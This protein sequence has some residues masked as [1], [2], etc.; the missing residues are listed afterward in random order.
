MLKKLPSLERLRALREVARTGG[1]SA[2]ADALAITQ[3]A[4]SN[5]IRL[6]EEQLGVTLLERVGRRV[7]LTHQGEILVGAA[8]RAFKELEVA[9][10]EISRMQAEIMGVLVV[11][12]GPTVTRHLL[13]PVMAD[14][15]TRHPGIDV[16]VLMGNADVLISGIVDGVT[17]LGLFT[18]P[19]RHSQLRG[20]L[21]YQDRFV[22][23][24]PPAKAHVLRRIQPRDLEGRE[25]VL[26][27]SGGSAV[28]RVIDDWLDAADRS[29]IRVT[30]IGSADAQVAFVRAGLGWA[31][32]PEI[33]AREDAQA[34]RIDVLELDPPLTR[35]LMLI[36]RADRAARPIVAAALASFAVHAAAAPGT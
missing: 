27:E 6:L 13:P 15:R 3:P 8:A 17:D 22:R 18:G 21:F 7:A 14:L 36:W 31:I 19:V 4:V 34:G 28:R 5:Q 23:I 9:I 2:A 32:I 29:R 24:T 35:D 1:F 16:R 33:A 26:Y 11:A 10:E 30:D 25:L 12:A 20:S